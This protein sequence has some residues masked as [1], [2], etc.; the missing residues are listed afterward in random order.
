M[1]FALCGCFV[2]LEEP[3]LCPADDLHES[4]YVILALIHYLDV[5]QTN[6]AFRAPAII[7]VIGGIVG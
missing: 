7:G 5:V 6:R 2:Q 1:T 3:F 4:T